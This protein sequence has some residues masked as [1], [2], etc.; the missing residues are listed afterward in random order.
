MHKQFYFISNTFAEDDAHKKENN[1]KSNNEKIRHN[2]FQ[3][4]IHTFRGVTNFQVN[5]DHALHPYRKQGLIT[6]NLP[7]AFV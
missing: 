3:E 4:T 5:K 7:G 6:N 2:I 1:I